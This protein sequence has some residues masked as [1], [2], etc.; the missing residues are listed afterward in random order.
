LPRATASR[1]HL[2][3]ERLT[4]KLPSQLGLF[5]PDGSRAEA[6]AHLKRE[7]NRRHGRFAVRSAATLPLVGVYR[8]PSNGYDIC[9]VRGKMCF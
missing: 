6:V 5:D 1:M 7:V 8:D 2:F 3:A 9:D 4:P